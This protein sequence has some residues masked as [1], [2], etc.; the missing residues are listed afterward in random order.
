[1]VSSIMNLSTVFRSTT[2]K[3]LFV[4]NSATKNHRAEKSSA[5]KSISLSSNTKETATDSR[6]KELFQQA[7]VKNKCHESRTKN[8]IETRNKQFI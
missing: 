4:L 5:F 3:D 1:M 6:R 8:Q 2:E 7:I